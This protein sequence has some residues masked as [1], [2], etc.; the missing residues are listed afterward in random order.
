MH[1]TPQ[2]GDGPAQ[3]DDRLDRVLGEVAANEAVRA[4]EQTVCDAWLADLIDADRAAADEMTRRRDVTDTARSE[5]CEVLLVGD[6][7]RIAAAH[8]FLERAI[9]GLEESMAH[10]EAV[11]GLLADQCVWSA[12]AAAARVAEAAT[13]EDRVAAAM[14]R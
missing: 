9:R 14:R 8:A 10:Y 1:E 2:H 11:H 12:E 7:P 5:L 4:A 3:G 6:A 13:D